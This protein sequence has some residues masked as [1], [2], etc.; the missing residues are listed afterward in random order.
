M[1]KNFEF[2]ELLRYMFT[3]TV[4][5]DALT[6]AQQEI[7]SSIADPKPAIGAAGFLLAASVIG[8]LIYSIQSLLLSHYDEA[9]RR[10][11]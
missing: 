5:L 4:F 11:Y 1:L 10:R 3:G 6:L 8:S 7:R 2:S 9:N